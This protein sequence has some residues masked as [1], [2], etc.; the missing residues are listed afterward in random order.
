M[1][2]RERYPV[3]VRHAREFRENLPALERVL[4]KTPMGAYVPLGQLA[5]ISLT[6]RA[7][8]RD[9]DAQ[10]AGYVRAWVR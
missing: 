3:N 5:E 6:T 2:G 9:Q 7:M 10:L 8:I 1:E 4:V